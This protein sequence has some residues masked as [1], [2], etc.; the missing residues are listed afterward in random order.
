[1]QP[2][3]PATQFLK[4]LSKFAAIKAVQYEAPRFASQGGSGLVSKFMTR[5]KIVPD[6]LPQP[7]PHKAEVTYFNLKVKMGM[8]M[9]ILLMIFTKFIDIV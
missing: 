2:I 4:N 7:T 6:L 5:H 1:M 9:N 3:R 8:S